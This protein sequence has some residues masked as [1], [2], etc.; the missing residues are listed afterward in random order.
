MN[1]MRNSS[2]LVA[3]AVLAGTALVGCNAVEDT[4]FDPVIDLPTQKVVL[5]GKVYGLGIRRAILVQN[6]SGG[7]TSS[8]S[9]QGFSGEAIGARGRES[10]F[11]FGALDSGATYNITVPAGLVPYGKICTVNNG[12][13][14]LQFDAS[15]VAQGAPQNIEVVCTND[16]AV[17]RRDIQVATP[18][19]FRN[20]PGARVRLM[21]EEGIYWADPNDPAD[22]DPEHVWFRDALVVVPESG[23]LPFQNIVTAYTE[24]DSTPTLRLVNR[25]NVANH[26]F[27]SP[28]VS[29]AA[30]VTNVAVGACKFSVGGTASTNPVETGGAVR[31]SRPLGV[32]TTPAMGAGGVTLEL[33]YADGTPVPAAGGGPTRVNLT[34]YG[35]NFTFPTQVSSGA[36]CP[37]PGPGETPFPCEVRGF[38]QIAV[39]QQPAGQRCIATSQTVGTRSPLLGLSDL[40]APV[41]LTNNANTNFAASANLALLDESLAKGTF[42]DTPTNFTGVR[43][44]CRALPAAD[45]VLHGT[46]HVRRMTQYAGS[47]PSNVT[48]IQQ[49]ATAYTFRR[50]FSHMLTFFDDGTFM[51]G[52]A[53]FG[54]AVNSVDV[55]NHVEYG[56]YDYVP[57]AVVDANNRVAGAKVR[58]TIHVDSQSSTTALATLQNGLSSAEGVRN[59]GTGEAQVRHQVLANLVQSTVP[60]TDLR[61]ITGTFGEDGSTAPTTT[62]T[63]RAMV[64]EE[65]PQVTG[66]MTGT[67]I[68]K[69]KNGFWSYLSDTTWGYH[70]G[71]EGGFA[72]AQTTCFKIENINAPSGIYTGVVAGGGTVTN[73]APLGNLFNSAQ[74]SVV[75]TPIPLQQPRLPGWRSWMPGSELRFPDPVYYVIAPAGNFA[76]AADPAV[77]PAGS[78]GD[79]S[80]CSSE[81]LGVRGTKTGALSEDF[82]PIYFCRNNN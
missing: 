2:R 15:A 77:F 54:D 29:N 11:S 61:T 47:D 81:I 18:A 28:T 67:W 64:F 14:T 43:V 50:E 24:E 17:D 22:G 76:A 57:N 12:S 3:A 51:M 5:D 46:Y 53:T 66:Q 56:F 39:V 79:T 73:C 36:E 62:S 63:R 55:R 9:V 69:D 21:T 6:T 42:N 72:N 80:W 31:Y 38:Y 40:S 26:Q 10:A 71:V 52:V 68:S 74:G 60:G 37:V 49:W 13:G 82:Q 32:T 41:A 8:R 23:V 1:L 4:G 19:G 44:Y 20:A 78:I 30:D 58:F 34:T 75:H 7:F 59:V 16:P 45:R 25:C 70:A 65:P 27:A 33:Q 35:G 48:A